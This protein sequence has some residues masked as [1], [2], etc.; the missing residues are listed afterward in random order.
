MSRSRAVLAAPSRAPLTVLF[1][2]FPGLLLPLDSIYA[3]PGI[4]AYA[5]PDQGALI[6]LYLVALA[7]VASA[8]T[9]ACCVLAGVI[10]GVVWTGDSRTAVGVASLWVGL[11]LFVFGLSRG[12]VL[13]STS[14]FGLSIEFEVFGKWTAAALSPLVALVLLRRL[15]EERLGHISSVLRAGTATT[16]AVALV[17]AG[18]LMASGR[19]EPRRPMDVQVSGSAPPI[20]LITIDTLSA[21]HL[22]IYG[23]GRTTT[24]RLAQFAGDATVFLRNYANSSFTPSSMASVMFGNRPWTHRVVQH[25]GRPLRSFPPVSLP[26]V[27]ERAGYYGA[28]VATNP[29]ATPQNLRIDEFFAALSDN[30]VCGASDPLWVLATE[31]QVAVKTSVVW[32]GVV[33]L[34]IWASDALSV[35]EGTHFDPELA[36]S[37]A[38]SVIASAPSDRPLFLWVHVMPPHDPYVTPPPFAG[39]FGSDPKARDRAST[40][41]PYLYEAAR[42]FSFPGAWVPRYDEAIRYVDHHVGAFLDHLKETG[43]YDKSLIVVTSDHGESLSKSYGGHGGPAL[44]DELIRV[45]LL[46]KTPGQNERREVAALSEQ[47]DLMPTLLDLAGIRHRTA[48]EGVSLVPAMDGQPLGRPVFAMNFQQSTRLGALDTGSVAMLEGPWKYVHYLGNISYPLIPRLEDGLYDLVED[49]HETRNQISTRP[50][51]AARMRGKILEMLREH[52]GPVE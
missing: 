43:Y 51:V 26:A 49:P 20:F 5:T 8:L 1:L 15:D 10:A 40:R 25:E 2:V 38:R 39:T 42:D 32:N 19:P 18:V 41:P 23:Y 47:A 11:A 46:I 22:P 7:L 21:S 4:L 31:L 28:S 50:D 17:C 48:A 36:F 24:P 16:I 29:W 14:T 35:C 37:E 13:W 3:L 44:H 6:F 45:P 33:S 34:L 52:G 27:L 12:L 30:N 9:Y